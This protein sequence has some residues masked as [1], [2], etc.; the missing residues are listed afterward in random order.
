MSGQRNWQL[1]KLAEGKCV[2]CGQVEV[3]RYRMCRPCRVKH[4]QSC[5]RYRNRKKTV[6]A[7]TEL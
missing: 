5:L 7:G 2:S 3:R 6:Y 4:A 1:K